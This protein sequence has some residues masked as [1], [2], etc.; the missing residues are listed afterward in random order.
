MADVSP[1]GLPEERSQGR[2]SSGTKCRRMTN[3]IEKKK[4]EE[5]DEKGSTD[6]REV[7]RTRKEV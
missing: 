1:R 5:K 6:G 4:V 2:Q 3:V 7:R